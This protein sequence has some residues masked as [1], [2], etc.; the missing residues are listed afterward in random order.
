M[1]NNGNSGSNTGGIGFMG[2]LQIGFIILKLCGVIDWSWWFV[3]APTWGTTLILL[4]IVSIY[5]I[6]RWFSRRR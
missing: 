5:L 3:L 1:S 6:A 4:M 2:A